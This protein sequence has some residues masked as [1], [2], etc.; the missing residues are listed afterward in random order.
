M[1]AGEGEREAAEVVDGGDG[2]AS[3]APAY[4]AAAF[5]ASS[6]NT[7]VKITSTFLKW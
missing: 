4:S 5:I 2:V 3:L 1:G 7:R 6:P